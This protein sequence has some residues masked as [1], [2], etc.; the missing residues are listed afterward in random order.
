MDAKWAT[1]EEMGLR[2]VKAVAIH[3]LQENVWGSN[4]IPD[5][6]GVDYFAGH[7][8]RTNLQ[9]LDGLPVFVDDFYVYGPLRENEIVRVHGRKPACTTGENGS[10]KRVVSQISLF[11]RQVWGCEDGFKN[12]ATTQTVHANSRSSRIVATVEKIEKETG[13]RAR[14]RW[15]ELYPQQKPAANFVAKV[16]VSELPIKKAAERP[17][18][19][20]AP[21]DVGWLWPIPNRLHTRLLGNFGQTGIGSASRE[22]TR[23]LP[24]KRIRLPREWRVHFGQYKSI[25]DHVGTFIQTRNARTASTK[26]YNKVVCQFEAGDVREPFG[27][28]LAHYIDSTNRH[29][30]RTMLHPDVQKRGCTRVEISLY[31]CDTEDLSQT[32]AKKLIAEALEPVSTEEGLFV[33]QPPAKQWENLVQHLDRCMLLGHR[34]QGAIY[35]AKPTE[36]RG[37]S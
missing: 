36:C 15:N 14:R 29:L 20:A 16:D 12:V 10:G 4:L 11:V 18:S 21:A 34:P 17:S 2:S 33:V 13:Y 8:G 32:V 37:C 23:V 9:P 3:I 28:H 25:G 1:L 24:T 31:A 5:I 19:H 27:G 22:R 35:L 7:Q 30:R 26:F 6:A